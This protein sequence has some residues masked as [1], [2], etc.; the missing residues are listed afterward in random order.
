MVKT[1]GQ[2]TSSADCWNFPSVKMIHFRF[3]ISA[4][5]KSSPVYVLSLDYRTADGSSVQL[6]AACRSP[7]DLFDVVWRPGRSGQL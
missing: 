1:G 6:V 5:V 4:E 7:D 3:G 2:L